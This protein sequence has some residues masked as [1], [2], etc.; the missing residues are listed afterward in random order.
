MIEAWQLAIEK[1]ALS[2]LIIYTMNA[3]QVRI[4]HIAIQQQK[5]G[6]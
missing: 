1:K 6:I 5:H 4:Y 2:F 3:K